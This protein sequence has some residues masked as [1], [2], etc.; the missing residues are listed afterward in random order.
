MSGTD[1]PRPMEQKRQTG[2]HQQHRGE[3]APA[4]LIFIANGAPSY[5]P[6]QQHLRR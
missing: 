2:D 5:K 4:S 6:L 1:A 3:P